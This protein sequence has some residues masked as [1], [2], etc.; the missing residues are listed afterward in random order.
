MGF[1][2]EELRKLLAE[3]GLESEAGDEGGMALPGAWAE[4]AEAGDDTSSAQ[5]H[6]EAASRRTSERASAST[7][8]APP[9]NAAIYFRD[10]SGTN[11]LSA[12]EE[13]ELAQ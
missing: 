7:E 3:A 13:I 4:G 6:T 10:I 1:D 5:Q 2:A 11:L 8:D 9:T 12:E